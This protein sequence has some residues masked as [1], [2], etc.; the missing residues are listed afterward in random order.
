MKITF[1]LNYYDASLYLKAKG[2]FS[3]E[4]EFLDKQDK[5]LNMK[6]MIMIV[7]EEIDEIL[8]FYGSKENKLYYKAILPA[9]NELKLKKIPGPIEIAFFFLSNKDKIAFEFPWLI[10]VLRDRI[11]NGFFLSSNFDP[12]IQFLPDFVDAK[13]VDDFDGYDGLLASFYVMDLGYET[14]RVETLADLR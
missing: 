14:I 11:E 10:P 6:D 1:Q 12:K 7:K 9:S 3:S 8:V 13:D 5:F 4:E 2:V